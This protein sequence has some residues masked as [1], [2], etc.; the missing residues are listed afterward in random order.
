MDERCHFSI[1]DIRSFGVLEC[2][3]DNYLLAANVRERLSVN[4]RASRKFDV[5]KFN[6]R[7]LNDVETKEDVSL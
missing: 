1:D 7:K 2:D 5:E 4:K 6:L 3:I